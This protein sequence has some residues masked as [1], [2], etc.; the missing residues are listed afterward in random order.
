M[1]AASDSERPVRQILRANGVVKL[2]LRKELLKRRKLT[3][4]AH[5]TRTRI[6]VRVYFFSV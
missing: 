2:I 4:A 6:L 1:A 5:D 3:F